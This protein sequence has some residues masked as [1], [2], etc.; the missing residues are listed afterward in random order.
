MTDDTNFFVACG[1]GGKET[2]HWPLAEQHSYSDIK[3]AAVSGSCVGRLLNL[4]LT[5]WAQE[6][7]ALEWGGGGGE[8][9]WWC[10]V[11]ASLDN[12]PLALVQAW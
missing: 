12:L 11:P 10:C 2:A 4:A 9:L 6:E 8:V 3:S 5:A 1:V 7:G